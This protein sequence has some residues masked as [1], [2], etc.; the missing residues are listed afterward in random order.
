MSFFYPPLDEPTIQSLSVIKTLIEEN[1]EYFQESPYSA[2]T[3]ALLAQWFGR[4]SYTPHVP[5]PAPVEDP[6]APPPPMFEGLR[7]EIES[8][9]LHLKSAKNDKHQDKLAYS[10]TAVQLLEKLVK[11]ESIVINTELVGHFQRAVMDIMEEVCTENQRKEVMK[12]L[13]ELVTPDNTAALT[14]IAAE[15]LN[16]DAT[17]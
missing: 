13:A 10:K 16:I 3:D 14:A 12:R 1:P 8:A 4:K 2:D 5:S 7:K 11:M 9:Y 15:P 6:D 17:E